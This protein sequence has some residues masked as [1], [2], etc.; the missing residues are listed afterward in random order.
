MQILIANK[1]A[2]DKAVKIVKEGGIIVY[3]TD[4][5]YGLGCDPFNENAVKKLI[6]V[7]GERKK[8]LPIL[9]SSIKDVEKIA[10]ITPLA[11]KLISIFW[12]GP[13]TIVL[14][15]KPVLPSIVTFGLD[16][17]GVRVPRNSFTIELIKNCGGLLIGTSANI[18]GATPC[19]SIEEVLK[20]LNQKVDLMID[21]GKTEIGIGST[22]IDLTK[23]EI[24]ILR[25]G[26]ISYE[27]IISAIK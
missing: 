17:V 4:T 3:P 21:G 10:F 2:I 11:R 23:K 12:P 8:P 22:V 19:T 16:S 27:E 9:A 15:K 20:Q 14:K 6:K 1:V 7:K 25:E 26:P 13:L 24:K 5:V 18:S